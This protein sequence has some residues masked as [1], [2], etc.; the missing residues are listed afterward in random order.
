MIGV[1]SKQAT[2]MPTGS[3]HC[4]TV[5]YKIDELAGHIVH[6]H[7]QT[8]RKTHS[9]AFATTA[10]VAREQFRWLDGEQALS[11]YESSPGKL[12]RFCAG[13][14]AHIVAERKGEDSVILRVATLDEDPGQPAVAHIWVSHDVDWLCYADLVQLTEGA[15][16]P[17]LRVP[18]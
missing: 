8:C 2:N 3:C 7:C 11:A 5:R 12:R 16:S 15:G 14:G 6:C 4:G 9:A 18:S 1:H 17:T 10:R 13:C